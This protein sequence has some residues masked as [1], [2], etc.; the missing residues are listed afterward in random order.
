V[1]RFPHSGIQLEDF[2]TPYAELLLERYRHLC[3]AWNDDV[4]GTGACAT[5][6]IMTALRAQG[7]PL[8]ALKDMRI[9]C[10]GAGSAGLGVV[11]AIRKASQH[12]GQSEAAAHAQFWLVDE[13]GLL[14]KD[15]KKPPY[16][17]GQRPYIRHDTTADDVEGGLKEGMRLKQVID[18]VKPDL[19]LG[20]SGVGGAFTQDCI[21]AMFSH[22]DEGIVF[23]M[24]N[25]KAECS[26]DDV[27]EWSGGRALFASGSGFPNVVRDGKVVMSP[28]QS[29]N[30]YIF[31]S[32]GLGAV[33]SRAQHVTDRMIHVAATTLASCVTQEQLD[34][35]QL[36][37]NISDIRKVSRRIAVEVA[38]VAER[39]GL[40]RRLPVLEGEGINLQYKEGDA[41]Q[42]VSTRFRTRAEWTAFVEDFVWRPQYQKLVTSNRRPV[43]DV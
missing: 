19:L 32:L 5:A 1:L 43:Q 26:A 28:A 30:L 39:Q 11:N 18:E 22:V 12:E 34:V 7:K 3:C 36:Y 24:S 23:A 10:L 4:Q 17:R 13:H 42:A 41:A 14:T 29:N 16:F 37:P 8:S 6:G 21:E 38:M 15:R 35:G 33:V 9:V 20:L 40:A 31:P 25:P 2:R 27:Y